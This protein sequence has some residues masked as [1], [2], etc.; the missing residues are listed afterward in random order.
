[1]LDRIKIGDTVKVWPKPGLRVQ[2][3]ADI[4]G[5]WL[6]DEGQDVVWTDWLAAR[7]R[8]GSLLLTD[9]HPA[10]S[11]ASAKKTKALSFDV[12]DVAAKE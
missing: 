11:P 7:A 3:H 12:S 9:P 6:A 4:P 1:M 10:P 2:S 8:D 5:R